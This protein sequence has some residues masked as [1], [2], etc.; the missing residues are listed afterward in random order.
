MYM[1]Y[2]SI[3]ICTHVCMYVCMYDIYWQARTTVD[4]HTCV[5]ENGLLTSDLPSPQL[6][7]PDDI[8]SL[9]NA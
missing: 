8:Q 6:G 5:E 9:V 1:C 4:R 7:F 3:H 2:F